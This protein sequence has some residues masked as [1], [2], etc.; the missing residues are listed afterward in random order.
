[1]DENFFTL[2]SSLICFKLWQKYDSTSVKV[3][4]HW[5]HY[6]NTTAC[7]NIKSRSGSLS[8]HLENQ[9]IFS[10]APWTPFYVLLESVAEQGCCL[11][12]R[13]GWSLPPTPGLCSELHCPSSPAHMSHECTPLL[14]HLS[15]GSHSHTLSLRSLLQAS[16]TPSLTSPFSLAVT[17]SL[18]YFCHSLVCI[19]HPGTKSCSSLYPHYF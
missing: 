10:D 6:K 14:P 18:L 3:F 16:Y 19:T 1:M 11:Q 13:C 5:L 15:L 4:I 12:H 17:W 2:T 7:W 8:G 9:G